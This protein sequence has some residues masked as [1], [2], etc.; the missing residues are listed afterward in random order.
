MMKRKTETVRVADLTSEP[1]AKELVLSTATQ[2][3]LAIAEAVA[4]GHDLSPLIERLAALPLHERYAWYVTSALKQVLRDY[5]SLNVQADLGTFYEA[6]LKVATEYLP[7]R[8]HQLC[9]FLK[10]LIGEGAMEE[11]VLAA[12]QAAKRSPAPDVAANFA[13]KPAEEL[14]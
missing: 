5:D 3:N 8:L 7:I 4:G 12:V 14:Q 10:T 6:N 11:M 1:G 13:P 9:V 2:L